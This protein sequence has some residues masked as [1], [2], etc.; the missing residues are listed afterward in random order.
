MSVYKFKTPAY[1]NYKI[2]GVLILVLGIVVFLQGCG[3]SSDTIQFAGQSVELSITPVSDHTLRVTLKPVDE[4]T[5]VIPVTDGRVLVSDEWKDPILQLTELS[6]DQTITYQDLRVTVWSSPLSVEVKTVEGDPVQHLVFDEETGNVDFDIGEGPV[7]GLGNG[8]QYFDRRGSFYSME[9]GHRPGEYLVFGARTPIPFLIGTDGWSMFV[10][11]PYNGRFDLRDNPGQFLPVE[12]PDSK[13]EASL[14]VDIFVTNVDAPSRAVSEYSKITGKPAMPPKWALGYMQ[15]HRNL[16]EAGPEGIMDVARTFR[17]KELPVDALIY[18]G[19]YTAVGWNIDNEEFEFHSESFPR[20][21]A[22]L[23]EMHEMNY[24]VSLHLTRVPEDLHGHIPP[25]EEETVNEDHVASYWDKHKEI[26]SMGIDGWWPDMGDPLDNDE[27]LTRHY[28]YREGPLQERPTERPWSLHRTGFAG[29]QRF[30]G[31]NWSGDVNSSWETLKAHVPVGIN[32]SLSTSPFWG[33][34][35]GG[36]YPTE[37]FTGELYARWFQFSTFTPSFRSHGVVWRTRLPWGWN[38]G[39][40]GPVQITE[41]LETGSLAADTAALEYRKLNLHDEDIEPIIKKFL[42][43]RYRLMPYTYT[44]VRQTHDSGLPPM[45]ALWL[46]YPDDRVAVA[47]SHQ[48]LWGRDLLIAPIVDKGT[49]GAHDFALREIYLPEGNWY[50]FWRPYRKF[51]GNQYIKQTFALEEMPIYVR[52]GTILP[53]DPVRQ[54][55]DEPTDEPVTL[56]IYP[57]SDGEFELY[58]DDGK[59][60]DFQDGEYSWTHLIWNDEAQMLTIEPGDGE[61]VEQQFKI[62]L[63]DDRGWEEIIEYRGDRI[64]IQFK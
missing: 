47:Q 57:G 46:H 64:Q 55:V 11:R 49:H 56:R 44:T 52:A 2:S 30:G 29:I 9:R 32:A 35:A 58:D 42:E 41:Y 12:Q 18:L 15:S 26:F 34:D 48:Y 51:P 43:L 16:S 8:G 25:Q 36:F 63:A 21:Q 62:E 53:L 1:L 10:H 45:R 61:S 31:W 33:T 50:D 14:P 38:P 19:R 6:G 13:K 60:L 4:D 39:E 27:R 5:D 17:E 54:Y 20:P 22:M 3:G 40:M 37:D 28:M 7:F 23:D 24:K 59:T